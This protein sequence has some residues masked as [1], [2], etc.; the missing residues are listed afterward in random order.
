LPDAKQDFEFEERDSELSAAPLDDD[1]D[2]L[3]GGAE[4]SLFLN[5][6]EPRRL[7]SDGRA[8]LCHRRSRAPTRVV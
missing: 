5:V 4:K 3:R 6:G 7:H 1:L 8:V 2:V